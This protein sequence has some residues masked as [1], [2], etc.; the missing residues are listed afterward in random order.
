MRIRWT[1]LAMAIPSLVAI[2]ALYL[3]VDNVARAGP[4][5]APAAA[6]DVPAV[7]SYQGYL[8]DPDTGQPMPDG[9]YNMHFGIFNAAVAG[10]QL[11]E[12]PVT[13]TVV[14][15]QVAG[16][17]FTVLLGGIIP[18]S[19][20]VFAGGDAFLEVQVNGETLTPRQPITAVA[21][22][23]VA[24][25]AEV[26]K[27]LEVPATLQAPITVLGDGT[28][29]YD[30]SI[31]R[32]GVGQTIGLDSGRGFIDLGGGGEDGDIW[33]RDTTEEVSIQ[34]DGNLGHITLGA[35]AEDGDLW[36]QNSADATTINLDGSA[37]NVTYQGALVGA[38]PRPAYDSGFVAIAKGAVDAFAH[39][40][41]GDPEDYF[42]DLR[43]KDPTGFLAPGIN[44]ISLGQDNDGAAV[45]GVHYIWL[46]DTNIFVFRGGDDSACEEVQVRIWEI[47]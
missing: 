18:L 34:L 15:V 27:T 41:G 39:N 20:A 30:I 25:T 31:T 9:V 7:I 26:A 11:W 43:C 45:T 44:I 12:E 8:T 19:P 4:G 46:G 16:G 36:L 6:P 13:P 28:N 23:M 3:A 17:V 1:L 29:A 5:S 40:V 38:F 24:E 42:I 22:A 33:V 21:Y 35:L 47:K 2:A 32:Q 37:G 10:A 14:P